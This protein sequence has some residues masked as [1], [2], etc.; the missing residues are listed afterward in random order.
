MSR[1]DAVAYAVHL[2]LG[3]SC[4]LLDVRRMP[5]P[6]SCLLLT[7]LACPEAHRGSTISRSAGLTPRLSFLWEILY[8]WQAFKVDILRP[9]RGIVKLCCGKN[10]AVGHREIML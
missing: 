10:N 2:E 6:V 8:F 9:D 5:S 7:Y 4:W 1:S 3:V